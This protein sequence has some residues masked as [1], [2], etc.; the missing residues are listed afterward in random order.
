MNHIYS[1][2]SSLGI[3]Y[4]LTS[5]LYTRDEM[6]QQ[7]CINIR[8]LAL[9]RGHFTYSFCRDS[10]ENVPLC[11][12]DDN[13]DDDDECREKEKKKGGNETKE[14]AFEIVKPDTREL[15]QESENAKA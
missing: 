4:T 11:H 7:N 12:D 5:A 13:D 14:R 1:R 15:S 9:A 6:L 10:S 2:K 3:L 8:E